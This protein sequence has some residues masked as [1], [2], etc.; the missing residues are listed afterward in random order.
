MKVYKKTMHE[1]G[2]STDRP[3]AQI[4]FLKQEINLA[5]FQSKF[6]IKI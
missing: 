1:V 3:H 5:R 6:E 4:K 2:V